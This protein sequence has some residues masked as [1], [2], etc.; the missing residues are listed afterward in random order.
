LNPAWRTTVSRRPRR[1]GFDTVP[2]S[3]CVTEPT[4]LVF[5][6]IRAR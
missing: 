4:S 2:L 1:P 6:E 3:I 5:G